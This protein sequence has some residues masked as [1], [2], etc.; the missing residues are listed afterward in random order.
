MRVLGVDLGGSGARAAIIE[1][2]R[3]GEV[4]SVRFRPEDALDAVVAL[5]R[6]LGPFDAAG[7][8]VPG[9]VVRGVVVGAPNLP[10]LVG[11]A[12]EK[13]W[14]QAWGVPVKVDNDANVAALGAARAWGVD[15][16]ALLTLGTGV[17]GGLVLGGRLVR[18]VSG[19]AA[20]VGHLPVGGAR[21]CGCGAV[22]CLETVVGTVGLVQAAREVGV[23]VRDGQAVVEAARA[24]APWAVAAV[25]AAGE[26]LGTAVV[27]CVAWVNP[28]RI[29]IVGGLAAAKDLLMPGVEAAR[30]R[31]QLASGRDVEIVWGTRADRWAIVGAAALAGGAL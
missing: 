21:R 25:E 14:A 22:G 5:G 23:D 17:G 13:A 29:G 3:V 26:A 30:A 27:T 15:D 31:W 4:R 11:V 9:Q 2:D 19:A 8:G 16:L 28:A 10:I 6:E 20:E 24:G 1:G 12:V 18:G 7:V